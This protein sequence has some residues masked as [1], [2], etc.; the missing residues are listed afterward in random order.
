MYRDFAGR[1][2]TVGPMLRA[3]GLAPGEARPQAGDET[4]NK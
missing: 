1:D 3:R 4:G 2:P